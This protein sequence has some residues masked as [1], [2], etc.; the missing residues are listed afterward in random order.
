MVSPADNHTLLLDDD[1][2]YYELINS[3]YYINDIDD[4]K[5]LEVNYT[6]HGNGSNNSISSSSDNYFDT[7]IDNAIIIPSRE[8]PI[9]VTIQQQQ[10]QQ[11][12]TTLVPITQLIPVAS[13][14]EQ[15][16][17]TAVMQQHPT[18]FLVPIDQRIP[19]RLNS[20]AR[21]YRNVHEFN[22]LCVHV[23]IADGLLSNKCTNCGAFYSTDEAT[24]RSGKTHYSKCCRGGEI[25]FPFLHRPLPTIAAMLDG[26]DPVR[27]KLLHNEIRKINTIL[28]FSSTIIKDHGVSEGGPVG[29]PVLIIQGNIAHKIGSLFPSD[30]SKYPQYMQSYFWEP[31]DENQQRKY[32]FDLD[33]AT[34]LLI[35]ELRSVLK[36]ENEFFTSMNHAKQAYDSLPEDQQVNYK[37]AILDYQKPTGPSRT[38]NA[39]QSVEVAALLR[40]DP[41]NPSKDYKRAIVVFP[42][43]QGLTTIEYI[44]PAYFP[45]SYPLFHMKG[46]HGWHPYLFS[47]NSS[48]K[49]KNHITFM[50]YASYILQVRDDVESPLHHDIILCGGKLTQQYILDLFVCMESDRLQYLRKNQC[51]L[52]ASLYKGLAN[53]VAAKEGREEGRYCVLPST[54][55]G[56]PRWFHEEYQDSMAR[57]RHF[58]KPDLFVTFTCSPKWPEIV[59]ALRINQRKSS[60][61]HRP[62]IIS[63]V[64]DIKLRAL[65]DDIQKNE[66]F[67]EVVALL[68]I[69]EWQKRNLPHAHIL[70]MLHRNNKPREPHEY[71]SISTAELPNKTQHPTLHELVLTHM[72]HG[73]CGLLNPNCVCM[74]NG[75]CQK[76]FPKPFTDET[77]QNPDSYPI[78]RRRS[79]LNGGVSV[80]IEKGGREFCVDNSWI[81]PYNPYLLL[82]YQAHINVEICNTVGA[83]K[84]L[85]KYIY[86]GV[87]KAIVHQSPQTAALPQTTPSTLQPGRVIDEI[88][89]YVECRYLGPAEA[90]NRLLS[91]LLH[92][93]YPPVIRLSL[94]LPGE[95]WVQYEEGEEE[96]A[97]AQHE[98]QNVQGQPTSILLAYFKAVSDE[99][100]HRFSVQQRTYK[101]E[102]LPEADQ[103]TYQD[104]PQYFVHTSSKGIHLWKR[105]LVNSKHEQPKCTKGYVVSRLR[106]V[107]PSAGD[108]M[109][110]RM[111]LINV[112]GATSFEHLK[113]HQG[114]VHETFKDACISMGLVGEDKE[115][116][117]CL[118]DAVDVEVNSFKLRHLF[119]LILENNHPE[120]P[121][122]LWQ[123]FQKPFSDDFRHK[124]VA[125]DH[126]APHTEEDFSEALHSISDILQRLSNGS[127]FLP[128]YGLPLPAFPRQSDTEQSSPETLFFDSN[129]HRPDDHKLR[130]DA[131]VGLFN[132]TQKQVYDYIIKQVNNKSNKVPFNNIFLDAPGGTGKTFVINT[133]ISRLIQH[134][135]PFV[136]SAFS[137]IAAILLTAGRTTHSFFK[138][139]VSKSSEVN[140]NVGNR[141]QLGKFLKAATVIIIDEAPMLQR[142]QLE[143]I[144]ILF[145]QLQG[146]VTQR[147]RDDNPFAGKL[148]I[149]SGD[150]RQTLPVC[151]KESRA[152]IC[153]TILKRSFLWRFFSTIH[154]HKNERV[155]RICRESND[156][157]QLAACTQ[158]AE[159]VLSIGNGDVLPPL[160]KLSI[161]NTTTTEINTNNN[162]AAAAVDA[163]HQNTIDDYDKDRIFIPDQ[164][165][166]NHKILRPQ[167]CNLNTFI[168]WCYPDIR[169]GAN[170][171]HQPKMHERAILCP[172]NK[173]VDVINSVAIEMYD[174]QE[175]SLPS[176]SATTNIISNTILHVLKSADSIIM[177]TEGNINGGADQLPANVAAEDGWLHDPAFLMTSFPVEFLNTLNYSGVPPHT[178]TLKHGAALMLLRNLDVKNGLCNGTK[179]TFLSMKNQ[180]LMLVEKVDKVITA[181]DDDEPQHS[182]NSS[183]NIIAIPRIDFNVTETQLPF[184]MKRRQFPVKLA[185]AMTVNKSQGQSLKRVGIYLPRPL[186]SHGQLYV[187]IGRS[188]IPRE[189]YFYIED[190]ENEQGYDTQTKQYYTKNVVWNEVLR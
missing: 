135:V 89:D 4:E 158:F 178:L 120:S 105:R 30:D 152:G 113:T 153:A 74:K 125:N 25:Q 49:K 119:C 170:D 47:T 118:Q 23:H 150:F 165:V 35:E 64:F 68:A 5:D 37:M 187:A 138:L 182:S 14:E 87:S 101:G 95:Q 145:H 21:F 29:P 56:S 137:G 2:H 50:E 54:Y 85:H 20:I 140:C 136:A 66:I 98:L 102:I 65:L 142:E 48:A 27:S 93:S 32:Y 34:K 132:D 163:N 51:K 24:S 164:F 146:T 72:V 94:H 17:M 141:S 177:D 109:Y 107:P 169:D 179:L 154:L 28:G 52:K 73:P 36:E 117:I 189:T 9:N 133:V 77:T 111:L 123:M 184:H 55:I 144:H 11:P 6:T 103:L 7:L 46:E 171:P 86:K 160:T 83:V 13:Q 81:V 129:L 18:S 43:G 12:V 100:N 139:P 190:F 147:N 84:Y 159:F 44:H 78:L 22:N 110:M 124:R 183:N 180:Y 88:T 157:T 63:R 143:A 80:V 106:Y 38:H 121:T 15:P 128:D 167:Q 161:C 185:F 19:V 31:Q 79:P 127:K 3:Y 90:V 40:Y 97:I 116:Q 96:E 176:A 148:L 126:S 134:K 76:R 45:L 1:D 155:L 41:M 188:G 99:N 115:W 53:A 60:A 175:A 75:K 82:R 67:G 57:V 130:A 16:T 181:N 10:Q 59:E 39:P 131:N 151:P 8:Q 166:F 26:E 91:Q 108:L 62:D 186:F 42:K 92:Q 122:K 71:D 149:L 174:S 58:G 156:E 61:S 112:K 33:G 69:V 114:V 168:R 162:T 70:I 104:F 173:D 172:L